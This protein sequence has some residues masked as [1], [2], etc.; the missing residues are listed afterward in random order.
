MPTQDFNN[1]INITATKMKGKKLMLL[2][3]PTVTVILLALLYKLVWFLAI[4]R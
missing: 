2:F 1:E 3:V 4:S